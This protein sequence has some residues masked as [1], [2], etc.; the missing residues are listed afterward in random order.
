MQRT[1]KQQDSLDRKLFKAI[2]EGDPDD[3]RTALENGA[4]PNAIDEDRLTP[5]G[6]F[7]LPESRLKVDI[8]ADYG[9]RCDGV[10]DL[11]VGPYYWGEK[12]KRLVLLYAEAKSNASWEKGESDLERDKKYHLSRLAKAE[13][14][15]AIDAYYAYTT[16]G[17]PLT[18]KGTSNE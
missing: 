15:I 5:L 16:Q 9:G 6:R 14:L 10:P 18:K 1:L 4:D 7:I 3:V 13:L 12:I 2:A 8:I 11:T 17:N